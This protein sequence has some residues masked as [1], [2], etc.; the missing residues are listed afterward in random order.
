MCAVDDDDD[1]DGVEDEEDDEDDVNDD[2]DDDD[3]IQD[4][5]IVYFYRYVE[6]FKI[7]YCFYEN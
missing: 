5:G 7:I 3:G 6:R 2:D 4:E 1:D